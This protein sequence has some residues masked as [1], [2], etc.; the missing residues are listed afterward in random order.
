[1]EYFRMM[2]FEEGNRIKIVNKDPDLLIC[3][4]GGDGEIPDFTQQPVPLIST[5]FKELLEKYL[6]AMDFKPCLEEGKS[7]PSLWT[8]EPKELPAP[9]A[10][11]AQDGA[12]LAVGGIGLY[13]AVRVA[14][15]KKD[16]YLIS[17]ALAESLL[18]RGIVNLELERIETLGG[19]KNGGK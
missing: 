15:Y 1:M 2:P 18:R 5:R 6:P 4:I 8:F 9:Q 7:E 3:R 16:S 13:P 10:R 17:L 11:F 12:V 14:N 19:M